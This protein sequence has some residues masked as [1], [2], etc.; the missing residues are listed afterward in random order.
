MSLPTDAQARKGLP[1]FTGLVRYFPDA[2]AAV[3]QLS[4]IANEQH[5]PGEPLHWAKEKSKDELD[6]QLRHLIDHAKALNG[7]GPYRDLEGVMHATKNAWRALA[8]LQR[9][10]DSGMNIFAV[11]SGQPEELT[12]EEKIADDELADRYQQLSENVTIETNED[13][14]HLQWCD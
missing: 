14:A 10:A 4:N 2:L 13:G 12:T 5:N 11:L 1:V 9:M 3:A 8:N 7:G 6:A